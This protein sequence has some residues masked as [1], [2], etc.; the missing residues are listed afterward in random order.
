MFGRNENANL[1]MVQLIQEY[2]IELALWNCY[3]E[4]VAKNQDS[5][6]H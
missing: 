4:K 3:K 6:E 5:G 2:R 1:G